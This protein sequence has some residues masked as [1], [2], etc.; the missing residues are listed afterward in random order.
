MG[1][2]SYFAFGTVIH[3]A[4]VWKRQLF[5]EKLLLV[6]ERTSHNSERV[7]LSSLQLNA[8]ILNA[9]DAFPVGEFPFLCGM[10]VFWGRLF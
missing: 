9:K 7:F 1:T 10:I 6:L 8:E 5:E 4:P 3:K 2:R